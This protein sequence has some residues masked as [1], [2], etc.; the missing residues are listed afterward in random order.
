MRQPAPAG[1]GP[2]GHSRYPLW[3]VRPRCTAPETALPG[4]VSEAFSVQAQTSLTPAA[5]DQ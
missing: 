1:G 2:L 3:T 5:A 4:N